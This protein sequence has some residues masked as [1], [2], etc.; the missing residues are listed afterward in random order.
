MYVVAR[1]AGVL[2]EPI[3]GA[4]A[5]DAG[6]VNQIAR[7]LF[8]RYALGLEVIGILLLAATVGAVMLA[9]RRFE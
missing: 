3:T 6:S 5:A 8:T 1:S 4:Q 2:P 7:L 9:Q